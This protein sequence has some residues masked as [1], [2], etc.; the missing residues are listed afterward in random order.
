M[1]AAG[2]CACA[3]PPFT[4][5]VMSADMWSGPVRAW[6]AP[7]NAPTP[8][9]CRCA[10]ATHIAAVAAPPGDGLAA[11]GAA[12]RGQLPLSSTFELRLCPTRQLP[13]PA[14]GAP[15]KRAVAR[16][17]QR[18]RGELLLLYWSTVLRPAPTTSRARYARSLHVAT[19]QRRDGEP[20]AA[21]SPA[22]SPR[23]SA[24]RRSPV[25]HARADEV[26]RAPSRP[27]VGRLACARRMRYGIT[28]ATGPYGT[29]L[30]ACRVAWG[31]VSTRCRC[32][33]AASRAFKPSAA[34]VKVRW[35]AI[36]SSWPK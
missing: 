12:R 14:D 31:A 35:S 7:I 17:R 15:T 5:I 11:G 24:R 9:L 21:S 28:S 22:A 3:H 23:R 8:R 26:S 25:N 29:Y 34:S 6:I 32:D 33:R 20:R 10:A 27:R 1:G 36:P 19:W 30:Y 18:Q 16:L 4:A 13:P 2:S